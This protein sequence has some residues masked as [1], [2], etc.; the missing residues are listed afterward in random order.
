M[1]VRPRHK[2]FMRNVAR[3]ERKKFGRK[4]A[5]EHYMREIWEKKK[6]LKNRLPPKGGI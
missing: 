3:Q 6:A 1:A 4:G 5:N 2:R